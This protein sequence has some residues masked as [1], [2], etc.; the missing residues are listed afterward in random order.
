MKRFDS[1]IIKKIIK[2][3]TEAMKWSIPQYK[4]TLMLP[5]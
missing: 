1:H 5:V 3:K 4:K 2:A